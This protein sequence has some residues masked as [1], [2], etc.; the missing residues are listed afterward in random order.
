VIV[1]VAA[2]AVVISWTASW[3]ENCNLIIQIT[4]TII[5]TAV[6]TAALS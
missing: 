2:V 4:Q 3:S 5:L 6:P 1:K